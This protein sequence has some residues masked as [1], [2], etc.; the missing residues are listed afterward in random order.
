MIGGENGHIWTFASQDDEHTPYVLS[1]TQP[2]IWSEQRENYFTETVTLAPQIE[3]ENI[4]NLTLDYGE[5]TLFY[6]DRKNQLLRCDLN[7]D[8]EKE[9]TISRYVNSPYHG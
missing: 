2:L 4:S 3:V 9:H 5:N 6:I 7:L 8:G 1:Q